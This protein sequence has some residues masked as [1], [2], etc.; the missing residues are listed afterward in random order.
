M[1]QTIQESQPPVLIKE[2]YFLVAFPG[3]DGFL[4]RHQEFREF[5][6]HGPLLLRVPVD[7]HVSGDGILCQRTDLQVGKLRVVLLDETESAIPH[8]EAV[9]QLLRGALVQYSSD[10][11]VANRIVIQDIFDDIDAGSQM[12]RSVGDL[13]V[14]KEESFGEPYRLEQAAMEQLIRNH[15]VDTWYIVED[16]VTDGLSR[17]HRSGKACDFYICKLTV[18][19]SSVPKD[20]HVGILLE[21]SSG[22]SRRR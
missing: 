15:V 3:K 7:S 4:V 16:E 17:R 19:E 6:P 22:E 9:H 2:S 18:D 1:E 14:F 13:I 21:P 11:V 10:A 8:F 20:D 5:F 12:C